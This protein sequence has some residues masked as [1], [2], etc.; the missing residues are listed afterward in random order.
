MNFRGR[1][2]VTFLGL[3]CLG[4]FAVIF[5]SG[6]PLLDYMDDYNVLH[7]VKDQ[8]TGKVVELGVLSNFSSTE[9]EV[10]VYDDADSKRSAYGLQKQNISVVGYPGPVPA[11]IQYDGKCYFLT[12][13]R[14]RRDWDEI[15]PIW[16]DETTGKEIC[17]Y[18]LVLDGEKI[19]SSRRNRI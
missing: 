5:R 9:Y 12:L 11:L 7:F 8:A 15:N 14:W 13:A 2:V 10:G 3:A 6:R 1:V 18:V 19:E 17:F 4:I 16:R